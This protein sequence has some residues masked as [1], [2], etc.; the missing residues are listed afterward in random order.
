[1]PPEE[2]GIL[3]LFRFDIESYLLRL[4]LAWASFLFS[5][6][7]FLMAHDTHAGFDVGRED[8]RLQIMFGVGCWGQDGK[9]IFG[10][11][12]RRTETSN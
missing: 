1:M 9:R 2:V 7:E 5:I 6:F 8:G 12:A 4:L 10:V 3:A 11:A